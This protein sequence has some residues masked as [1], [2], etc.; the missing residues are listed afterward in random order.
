[1]VIVKWRI[2]PTK[3]FLFYTEIPENLIY[4]ISPIFYQGEYN[5]NGNIYNFELDNERKRYQP[6]E[7]FRII[8]NNNGVDYFYTKNENYDRLIKDCEI[9]KWYDNNIEVPFDRNNIIGR[10]S[11]CVF[12]YVENLVVPLEGNFEISNDISNL[13]KIEYESF[14]K[15]FRIKPR[16]QSIKPTA[17]SSLL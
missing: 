6:T 8:T 17:N 13:H 7:S 3:D 9:L 1:M 16:R 4:H 15:N 14:L 5:Q 11:K 10:N 2:D 12:D